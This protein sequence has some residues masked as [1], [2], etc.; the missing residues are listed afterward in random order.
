MEGGYL[1]RCDLYR[2]DDCTF[3]SVYNLEIYR[4]SKSSFAYPQLFTEN[5]IVNSSVSSCAV[6]TMQEGI[7]LT[8]EITY[9]S[10]SFTLKAKMD[11]MAGYSK[12]LKMTC[13]SNLGETFEN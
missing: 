9:D 11:V 3:N 6:T 10:T 1:N 4:P 5:A 8:P 13:T 7:L 12:Q 2:A